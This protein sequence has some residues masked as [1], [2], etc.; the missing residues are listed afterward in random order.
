M[1]Q[2]LWSLLSHLTSKRSSIDESHYKVHLVYRVY[3]CSCYDPLLQCQLLYLNTFQS[4]GSITPDH[5]SPSHS[6]LSTRLSQQDVA[7]YAT[8]RSLQRQQRPHLPNLSSNLNHS[9]GAA[10]SFLDD[11]N[12]LSSSRE[13]QSSSFLNTVRR[14]K[15]RSLDRQ[16][17]HP[18]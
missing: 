14:L 17:T 13:R 3:I 9:F 8:L 2:P 16:P 11:L 6:A 10:D 18:V 1:L 15:A 12:G 4:I 7:G 5:M